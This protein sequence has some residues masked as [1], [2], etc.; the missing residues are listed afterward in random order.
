VG[1]GPDLIFLGQVTIDDIV[2]AVPSPWRREIGGSSI[3]GIAGARLWLDP[4]RIGIVARCGW[5]YPFDAE[6]MLRAAG[7]GHVTLRNVPEAHLIE[8]LIYETDGSRRCLPRNP[9]LYEVGHMSAGGPSARQLYV[10]KLLEITPTVDDV[11]S[12]WLPAAAMHFC[13]QA[14]SRH[15]DS[16]RALGGR[17]G[18]ISLDPSPYYARDLDPADLRARLPHVTSFMPSTEEIGPLIDAV[19]PVKAVLS[20]HQAGFPEVI[21][22]RGNEPVILAY[23]GLVTMLPTVAVEVVDATGAGD[24]FC[25]A[26]TACRMLGHTPE[27]AVRRAVATAALVVGCHGAEQALA[28]KTPEKIQ[29]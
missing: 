21:L 26:Y 23:E 12:A 18:R 19:G 20:L 10:D 11:P 8:W 27:D 15:P 5:D 2:P 4:A 13:P 3:Y 6:H 7:V 1:G 24:S 17:V 14:G 25:G 9:G 16:L 28:L 22:K 29:E